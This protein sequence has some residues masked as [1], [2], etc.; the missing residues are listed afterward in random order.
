MP[1]RGSAPWE[2]FTRPSSPARAHRACFTVELAVQVVHAARVHRALEFL[3]VRGD[4]R[5]G[6]P[7]AGDPL[8]QGG[9]DLG[10]L[11]VSG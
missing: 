2:G 5:A 3:E 8:D 7:G 1:P 10:V 6:H 4:R 11:R 9:L